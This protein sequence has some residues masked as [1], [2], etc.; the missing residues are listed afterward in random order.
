MGM[1]RRR[2]KQPKTVAVGCDRWPELFHGKEGVGGSSPP[3][4]LHKVP[5]NRHFVVACA[6]NTRT[7]S[8]HTCGTRDASRRLPTLPAQPHRRDTIHLDRQIPG[9]RAR[10]LSERARTRPPLCREGV[11][12][13]VSL[14]PIAVRPKADR[15]KTSRYP[16]AKHAL[17]AAPTAE[18]TGSPAA[19][20]TTATARSR[21]GW[22]PATAK[23]LFGD[24]EWKLVTTPSSS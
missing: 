16:A 14:V 22:I 18:K 23:K 19:L 7:H 9:K 11:I 1:R 10:S 15:Q 20:A 17:N 24:P 13:R 5:A 12:E 8:G 6:L 21:D 4:G 2:P 3:E